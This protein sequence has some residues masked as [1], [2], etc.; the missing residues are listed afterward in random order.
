MNRDIRQRL[1]EEAGVLIGQSDLNDEEK[2][3]L[4]QN[5]QYFISKV[6]CDKTLK[7]AKLQWFDEGSDGCGL[8]LVWDNEYVRGCFGF[9]TDN[10]HGYSF[11][12][13]DGGW[14]QTGGSEGGYVFFAVCLL[15][16]SRK[17][18]SI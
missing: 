8:D 3:N 15:M 12:Y 16:I 2:E 17:L 1:L 13:G 18:L 5:I 14:S 10:G 7:D 11:E 6:K 4:S 9:Y